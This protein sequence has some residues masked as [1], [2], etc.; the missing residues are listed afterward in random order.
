[1]S[2]LAE[3]LPDPRQWDGALCA[4][5]DPDAWFPEKGHPSTTAIRICQACPLRQACLDYAVENGERYGIWGGM[6]ERNRRKLPGYRTAT[7]ARLIDP[8][9]GAGCGTYAGAKAHST[10]GEKACGPCRQ[11]QR[12]YK[13][14][15]EAAA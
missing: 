4:Q 1:M 6:S 3:H 15:Q 14:G 9:P 7:D 12:E 11:V 10:R 5:S 13:Q 8:T 2:T